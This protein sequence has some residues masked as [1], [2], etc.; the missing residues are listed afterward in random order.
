MADRGFLIED[1]VKKRGAKLA[2]SIFSYSQSC[3]ADSKE[4]TQTKQISRAR[5]HVERAIQ[6][7]KL[8][9]ILKF[10]PLSLLHVSEQMFKVCAYLTNFQCPI[11]A[12]IVDL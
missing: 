5:I 12:D 4:V 10:F 11:I 1:E 6:R 2:I 7:I 8:F 9:K 3:A